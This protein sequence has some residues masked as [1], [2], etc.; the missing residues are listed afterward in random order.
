MFVEEFVMAV[1]RLPMTREGFE[2]LVLELEALKKESKEV[3]SAIAAAREYRDLSENAE[4]AAARERQG[5]VEGRI[6]ALSSML[7]RVVVVDF[8]DFDDFSVIKFGATVT[9]H[10]EAEDGSVIERVYKIVGEYEADV[11]KGLLSISSPL[12]SELVGKRVGDVVDVNTP[13]GSVL[14]KVINIEFK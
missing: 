2:S 5:V 10:T 13:R 4:Y 1:S 14:Y 6:L 9:L 7:S 3:I 8:K 12:A 11:S